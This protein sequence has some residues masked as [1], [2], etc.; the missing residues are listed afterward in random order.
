MAD[1]TDKE[2]VAFSNQCIRPLATRL[3]ALKAEIDSAMITWDRLKAGVK[4]IAE[5]TL[6]DG[7]DAEGASSLTGEDMYSL[8]SELET[9]KTQLDVAGKA[10]IIEKPC[11]TTLRTD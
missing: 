4:N 7:R 8:I 10:A 5:D 6:T 2:V 3:R 9:I 1:I 11:I